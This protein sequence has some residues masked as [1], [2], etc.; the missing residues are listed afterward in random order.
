M[1]VL[2]PGSGLLLARQ[3]VPWHGS[4]RPPEDVCSRAIALTHNRSVALGT[5]SASLG[6]SCLICKV[7]GLD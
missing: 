5:V 3:A 4:Q 1:C 2:H 7:E 6:H